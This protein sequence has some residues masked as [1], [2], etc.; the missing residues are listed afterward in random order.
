MVDFLAIAKEA[1]TK[2]ASDIHLA[3]GLSPVLRVNGELLPMQEEILSPEDTEE[4]FKTIATPE[5]QQQ[6]RQLGELDFAYSIPELT[7][8]RVNCYQDRL[9]IALALRLISADVPTIDELNLPSVLKS[10]AEHERGLVLV[11][12]PTGSGK[13]TTLAAM[14]DYLNEKYKKH[15]LTI[16][17][18]IEYIHN[19]KRS[20]I[21]QR[22][23]GENTTSFANA[24]RAA[25]RQ[26]PDVILVGEMR[27]LETISVALTA[28]ETGHL[29]L[30]TLHTSSAVQ[31]VDRIV[32]VFPP[33]QQQQ[34]RVQLAASL[35]GVI[36][37]KLLPRRN[38]KGRVAAFEILVANS[39]VSNLIREGKTH[40]LQSSLQTGA[41][42]G[43]V[44][45]EASLR[46]LYDKG[47]IAD[48]EG[49]NTD[50]SGFI[51]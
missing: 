16:E 45:M 17:D 25:L 21:N 43:M 47:L 7:R 13:S 46:D 39:A 4:I 1:W 36:A 38:G 5:Q 37:Q 24:L 9:G 35:K 11:T 31:T 33:H 23:I 18:P 8:F 3:V 19:H 6:F 42:Y 26:D 14:I 20:V 10:L 50:D 30:A 44:T 22:E 51:V 27:D 28:A 34:I 15:I 48:P 40:Q 32:D 41:R 29:V 49:K 2:K 12:G